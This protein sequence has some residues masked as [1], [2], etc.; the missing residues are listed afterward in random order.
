MVVDS[1]VRGQ[2]VRAKHLG[3]L[4]VTKRHGLLEVLL[5]NSLRDGLGVLNGFH[6]GSANNL[7]LGNGDE[8]GLGLGG[9]LE[10]GPDSL[11]ALQGR[12]HSVVRDGSTATLDVTERC[13]TGIQSKPVLVG[14]QILDHLCGDLL[15]I[16]VLGALCNDD[17]RL[18]LSVASVLDLVS[19]ACLSRGLPMIHLTLLTISHIDSCQ[20]SSLGFSGMKMKSAPV[21]TPAIRASQPQCLPMTSMTKAR[22]WEEAVASM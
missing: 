19:H 8:A 12:Q 2:V 1:N 14:E 22:E 21:A 6:E 11:H 7:V 13:D 10:N 9:G 4:G 18:A 16:V 15:A 17:N 3:K 20:F 5:L